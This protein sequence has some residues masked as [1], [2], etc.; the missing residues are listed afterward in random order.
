VKGKE[1]QHKFFSLVAGMTH[2]LSVVPLKA[3]VYLVLYPGTPQCLTFSM[4]CIS[5]NDNVIYEC[6]ISTSYHNS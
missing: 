4:V 5:A 2:A 1:W 3:D 6:G